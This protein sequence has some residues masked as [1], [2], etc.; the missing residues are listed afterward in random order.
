[1]GI[2]WHLA[3]FALQNP[4]GEVNGVCWKLMSAI[5]AGFGLVVAWL[6]KRL[7]DVEDKKEKLHEARLKDRID[8]EAQMAAFVQN[9]KQK[10][11]SSP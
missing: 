4:S 5:V 3:Y 2:A 8:F 1:M 9:L 10:R 6:I 11:G 7:A